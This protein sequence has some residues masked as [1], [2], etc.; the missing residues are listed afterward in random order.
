MAFQIGGA[1]GFG[2]EIRGLLSSDSDEESDPFEGV[3]SPRKKSTLPMDSIITA[4]WKVIFGLVS[5]AVV[6]AI[7]NSFIGFF[8]G[9]SSIHDGVDELSVVNMTNKVLYGRINSVVKPRKVIEADLQNKLLKIGQVNFDNT[10]Q[11]WGFNGRIIWSRSRTDLIVC[12]D[13]PVEKGSKLRLMDREKN[14]DLVQCHWHVQKELIRAHYDQKWVFHSDNFKPGHKI[15]L[16]HAKKKKHIA[17][18]VYI[19]QQKF[20]FSKADRNFGT[21]H[22]IFQDTTD[23]YDFEAIKHHTCAFLYVFYFS[24]RAMLGRTIRAYKEMNTYCAFFVIYFN[25]VDQLKLSQF[26]DL[27]EFRSTGVPLFYFDESKLLKKFPKLFDDYEKKWGFWAWGLAHMPQLVWYEFVGKRMRN[28]N[29]VWQMENDV[30]WTGD[31][32]LMVSQIDQMP[33]GYLASTECERMH[34][35]WIHYKQRNYIE[36]PLAA[37]C[38]FTRVSKQ[39]LSIASNDIKENRIAYCEMVF[40]SLSEMTDGC[41]F[42]SIHE[43]PYVN[44]DYWWW[45]VDIDVPTYESLNQ[46]ENFLFHRAKW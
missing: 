17:K 23:L 38:F 22:E 2:T 11:V 42:Q 39:I 33:G 25:D 40:P 43:Q 45:N 1:E 46:S 9:A 18:K 21:Y 5:L 27:E 19:A 34:E 29:R 3:Y 14:K 31:L 12:F 6:C 36:K 32:G 41:E 10:K 8:E 37:N 7:G 15:A 24:T 28:L 4:A 30:I 35:H 26:K 44:K 20:T 16:W 13:L